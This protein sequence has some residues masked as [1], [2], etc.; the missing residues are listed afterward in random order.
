MVR[1]NNYKVAYLSL[2]EMYDLVHK[3]SEVFFHIAFVL[4]FMF[5]FTFLIL[6]HQLG[7]Y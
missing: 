7:V 4:S 6:L 3:D 5:L 2:R 1:V